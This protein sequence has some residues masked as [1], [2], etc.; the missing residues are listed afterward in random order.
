MITKNVIIFIII[1][2]IVVLAAIVFFPKQK[3]FQNQSPKTTEITPPA[4]T[5]KVDD[6]TNAILSE[7]SD[8]EL[9][10]KE[11]EKDTSLII[12]DGQEISDFG[13]TINESE[14]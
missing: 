13:Q 14:F 11:E 9:L 12:L 5:G 2:V 7:I 4:A 8:E 3:T 1:V 6:L 10:I